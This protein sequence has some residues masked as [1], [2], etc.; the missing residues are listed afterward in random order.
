MTVTRE[1]IVSVLKVAD[2][3]VDFTKTNGEK[4]IMNCT[5]NPSKL[6][7]QPIKESTDVDKPPRKQNL[8]NVCV[9]DIDKNAWRSFKID[10]VNNFEVI[11]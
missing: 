3:K 4:R 10:N 1:E 8:S 7:P 9:F 5:L 11:S 2:V 6:P